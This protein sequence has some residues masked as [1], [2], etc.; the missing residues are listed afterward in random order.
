MSN[1][2]YKF[3]IF[4]GPKFASNIIRVSTFLYTQN[5]ALEANGSAI[6]YLCHQTE[7][8]RIHE[9]YKLIIEEKNN[10]LA[11]ITSKFDDISSSLQCIKSTTVHKGQCGE[12]CILTT[13]QE[14][15][16][17]AEISDVSNIPHA[18][19]MTLTL[20]NITVMIEVKTKTTTRKGDVIKFIQD[21]QTHK[22][23]YHAALFVTS[24]SGIPNKGEFA[25][26]FV[27]SVPVL[28]VS[29]IFDSSLLLSMSITILTSLVPILNATKKHDTSEE[30]IQSLSSTLGI[31]Y[32]LIENSKKTTKALHTIAQQASEQAKSNEENIQH[33]VT[34]LTRI[35]EM[36]KTRLHIVSPND[37]STIKAV[38]AS[39]QKNEILAVLYKE[40]THMQNNNGATKI[41]YTKLVQHVFTRHNTGYTSVNQMMTAIS[42]QK[43]EDYKKKVDTCSL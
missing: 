23:E 39:V 9:L 40:H 34:E 6:S 4:N 28:Y 21:I 20:D 36:Y 3:D 13:L 32:R 7:Q 2:L 31:A 19:D 29:K 8:Q 12:N 37:T 38:N 43:F 1:L 25:L 10:Q 17:K 16:P 11:N 14:C 15:F 26:E 5:F 22:H 27:E 30:I 42:K 24:S 41:P 33:C 18:G 35:T